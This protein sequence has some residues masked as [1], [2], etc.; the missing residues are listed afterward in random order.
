MGQ[1]LEVT[2]LRDLI[3][4]HFSGGE[5]QLSVSSSKQI[6]LNFVGRGEKASLLTNEKDASMLTS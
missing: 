4:F 5:S 2:G 1:K 3:T 6:V